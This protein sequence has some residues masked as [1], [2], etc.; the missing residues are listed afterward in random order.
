MFEL[1]GKVAF[2][3]G[4]VGKK[5]I[6]RAIAR[7]LAERGDS[8]A[9]NDLRPSE[10]RRRGLPE[11]VAEIEALGLRGLAVYGDVADS[12]QV[13][14]MFARAFAH[15]GRLDIRRRAAP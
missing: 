13:E 14:A 11:V 3:T 7:Q 9:V 6:G 5:G 10:S 2:V 1:N 15:F 4:A 12:A 8:V